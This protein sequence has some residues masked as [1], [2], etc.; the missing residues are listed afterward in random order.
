[1]T[2]TDLKGFRSLDSGWWGPLKLKPMSTKYLETVLEV[3]ES[4]S[5]RI[6]S[7]CDAIRPIYSLVLNFEFHSVQVELH[8][9]PDAAVCCRCSSQGNRI[10][11]V[12]LC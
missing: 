1:M 8:R 4:G 5:L 7:M 9:F 12:D 2:K 10:V 11:V 6:Q 3:H